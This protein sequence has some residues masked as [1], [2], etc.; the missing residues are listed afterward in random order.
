MKES[1]DGPLNKID[2]YRWEIPKSYNSGMRVPGLIYASSNLL[3]KIRQDQA[4]EQVANVAFL[5][6]I[7]GHSLA[8]P[9]IHWGYGFC[10]G[11]VAATTLDNGIISPGGIGFD[12]NCLSSDALILHPLGYTLKIKEFEKIWLEEKISCFDFEKEDLINSKIINFFKKFPDNEVYKITT[13]TGKTITATEDH[14]FY[15]KDGMIPLNKLKVGDE[16]AIYPFEGVPYE[17]SSSEI[18]LNEEKIKELL[19]KLGKGNNGNGLNQILSHLKKRGLLPLRYNSPQLPYIL[20]I[21]GYVFGDGNIHFANKKGKGLTSFY[22][23][24]EDLEEIKRDITHIGYNCSRVYSRTRDH[25]IDTLYGKSEFSST[26]TFCKVVSS[27]FAILLV[28]LGTAL[29]NKANQ[30]YYLPSWIFKSPLWQKRLFLAAFFGAE[31]STPKTLLNHKYTFYCPMISMNKQEGFIESG[32]KYLEEISDLLAEFGVTTQ[33]ISQRIEY[34]NKEG[35]ISHRLR[36]ILSDQTQDLINLYGKI[37][38]EYNKKR[39]FIANATVH[40]LKVKQLIIEKRN[41]IAIQAKELKTKEGIGAKAIYK[42]IDSSYTNLRFIERSIYEERKSSSRI[43]FNALSFKNF[44]NKNTEGLG[45]SGMLWDEIISK[46][47]VDFNDYVYDFTVEHPHHNFVANNFV[48]SNC[49]IRLVRTNLTLKE[50]KPKIE[51]LVD[52]LFRAIPS[53]LGSKGRIKIS[54]NEMRKVLREGTKWA[55][56]SGY[57]WEED[58][59]FTEEEGSMKEANPDLI[60]QHA[61]ERGKPQLGTL[62]SGNHFLEIQVVDKIYDPEIAREL[63]L[64]EG[65]ITVM[66]H[67]GSRGLGHQVCTDYLVTMQK[68]VQKYGIK[69]PDRQLACAPLDSPEG[70]NYYAAMAGAANYAWANRQCIMHWTREV[71]A[72]VFRSTPEELELK[73]IYDVAHNIAKIEEHSWGGQKIKLCVHRKG[74]TRAFPP[75][76][77]DIPERYQKI[78]QPVLIPGDM[79]RCSYCLVGTEKAMEETFGS[80]CHGAGRVMSR[81]AAKKQARGRDIQQELRERGIIVKAENRGTLVE[82]M[83]DAYKDVSEVVE[84]MHQTGISK[85]V[86]RMKPLGVIKG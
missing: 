28:G 75:F 70:K 69:L 74:A 49:G 47:K 60:S 42:Q 65:Q 41:G 81:M 30:D 32:R 82:E 18:I 23:K 26:E 27:S 56:K 44:M 68:A 83:S 52:E 2:D 29:G 85:K 35:N 54:Y 33:K 64:E 9:D 15:T 38:F 51:L 17:E 5:P 57:G 31:L 36:L 71:F 37:G 61:L 59:L 14:P 84:V 13:K 78:G 67:C 48:V 62:G 53:G 86:A 19:L 63:G 34:I 55:V 25:K 16:L 22:G 21:M 11:G 72:K 1:W 12:I 45:H 43:S 20:K 76:H 66:I 4:L 40:Y 46:Q 3:E 80:T 58:I 39:S 77:Q 10:V 50:V 79:G 73:L 6:G 7:V 24:A 8:M